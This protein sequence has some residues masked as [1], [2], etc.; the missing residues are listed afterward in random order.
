MTNDKLL[1]LCG[2]LYD[3]T[4]AIAA[5][6][7]S[8]QVNYLVSPAAPEAWKALISGAC[9]VAEVSACR[10]IIGRAAGDIP[11][12]GLAIFPSKM[13][14]HH[15][16]YINT[17]RIKSPSDLSNA[18]IGTTGYGLSAP[19]WIRGILR[20]Q[21]GVDFT[22]TRWVEGKVNAGDIPLASLLAKGEIDAIFA[23]EL[24][25]ELF[26]DGPIQRLFPDFRASERS[27]FL[28]TG[29]FPIMHCVVLRNELATEQNAKKIRGI[30]DE[31]KSLGSTDLRSQ[32][33]L[34]VSLPWLQA[35][36]EEM[37]QIHHDMWSYGLKEML[38][39]KTLETLVQYLHQDGLIDRV[40][41]LSELFPLD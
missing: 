5:G 12:M 9:D 34:R 25:N 20:D 15:S 31:A 33:G 27:Y 23:A 24:P 8:E 40:M 7:V 37:D 11:Y 13:F 32:T 41:P 22:H 39:V 18:T 36:L 29:L 38:N 21:H 3:R 6:E 19:V 2:G 17:D 4:R 1:R 10:Y 14:R 16:I 26:E 28:E 35:D 30:Y